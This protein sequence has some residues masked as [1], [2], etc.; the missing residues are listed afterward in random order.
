[1]GSVIWDDFRNLFKI[2]ELGRGGDVIRISSSCFF[3]II[4]F[5]FGDVLILV[6]SFRGFF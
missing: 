6:Y 3:F 4:A 1:M 2:R 5:F